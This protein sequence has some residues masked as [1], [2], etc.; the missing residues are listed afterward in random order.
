[1]VKEL[2]FGLTAFDP[3]PMDVVLNMN[4]ES[5]DII[6]VSGNTK[7]AVE[8]YRCD[9]DGNPEYVQLK[10]MPE[11]IAFLM[12]FG[13]D[14]QMTIHFKG[15]W[16]A[17]KAS[18]DSELPTPKQL[19]ALSGPEPQ[20]AK[21]EPS[22]GDPPAETLISMKVHCK[23]DDV[24]AIDVQLSFKDGVVSAVDGGDLY[25]VVHQQPGKDGGTDF[26]TEIHHPSGEVY[27]VRANLKGDRITFLNTD[28]WDENQ[29]KNYLGFYI[30]D[31]A[32]VA[33][34]MKEVEANPDNKIGILYKHGCYAEGMT[35]SSII[36]YLQNLDKDGN[37][38]P[39]GEQDKDTVSKAN[40]SREKA[41]KS[42]KKGSG[43]PEKGE[44]SC[45]RVKWELPTP[46]RTYRDA[47]KL[48]IPD[49]KKVEEVKEQ[50]KVGKLNWGGFQEP[51]PDPKAKTKRKNSI[52]LA[53]PGKL[54][55]AALFAGEGT[56]PPTDAGPAKKS[57]SKK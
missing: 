12:Q 24:E 27:V 11:A 45:G 43:P 42:G 17:Y 3:N 4:Q 39:T 30:K 40:S 15:N 29:L 51:E 47:G 6:S 36:P 14:G 22:P 44:W 38:I 33:A 18:K 25:K 48:K 57:W 7:I 52:E 55:A 41:E 49:F 50:K 9:K 28:L 16:E 46:E 5:C 20:T 54:N 10:V 8:D 19:I 2:K 1:M 21:L 31:E 23:E 34:I 13:P 35:M 53:K 32:K 56:S 26:V 37:A